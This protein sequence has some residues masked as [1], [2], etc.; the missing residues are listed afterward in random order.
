MDEMKGVEGWGNGR[1]WKEGEKRNKREKLRRKKRKEKR[2]G[3]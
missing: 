2:K 3:K 1:R